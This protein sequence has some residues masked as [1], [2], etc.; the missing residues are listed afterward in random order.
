MTKASSRCSKERSFSPAVPV[1]FVLFFSV[2][3]SYYHFWKKK[4]KERKEMKM[5]RQLEFPN[6]Q[7]TCEQSN[8][9]GPFRVFCVLAVSPRPGTLSPA[10]QRVTESAGAHTLV[11]RRTQASA[12]SFAIADLAS[13]LFFSFR[14][15]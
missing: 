1:F 8:A 11:R 3:D 12:S 4:K 15:V 5:K 14:T 2:P 9:K 13:F 6:V 10:S 7:F